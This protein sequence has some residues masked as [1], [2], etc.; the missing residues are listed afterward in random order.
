MYLWRGRALVLGVDTDSTPHAHHAIQL[1]V[2]LEGEFRLARDG[3]EL[4]PC[5]AAILWPGQQHKIAANG[6]LIAHLFIDPAQRILEPWRQRPPEPV[7]DPGLC[8]ALTDAWQI[9]RALDLCEPLVQQWQQGW[10]PG[11]ER[12]PAHDARIAQA[13][14]W[15]AADPERD[16]ASTATELGLSQRRFSQLFSLHTGLPLRRY[17][18]WMRLLD[19]VA[20]LATGANLTTAAHHAGFADLAHM[21]RVFHATFGV[22]PST[23]SRITIVA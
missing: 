5:R 1:S 21:S 16:A 15:L 12:A 7:I 22:V 18:L 8:E 23:L 10:L 20:R 3:A 9:P 2:A 14:A 19:A 13:L 17:L 4:K 6:A 11:F